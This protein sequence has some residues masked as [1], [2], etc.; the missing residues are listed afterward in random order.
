MN[1]YHE[2]RECYVQAKERQHELHA[3]VA[4]LREMLPCVQNSSEFAHLQSK[5]IA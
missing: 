2:A 1:E 4:E 5:P 3:H